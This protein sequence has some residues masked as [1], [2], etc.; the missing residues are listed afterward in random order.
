[1]VTDRGYAVQSRKTSGIVKQFKGDKVMEQGG[2]KSHGNHVINTEELGV[3]QKIR[4][5]F[6]EVDTFATEGIY[7]GE[8]YLV[9]VV[10]GIARQLRVQ[11]RRR[12]RR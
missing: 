11:W 2:T 4:A 1:M 9:G 3:N 10:C 8:E 5:S 7:E 12:W 6:L